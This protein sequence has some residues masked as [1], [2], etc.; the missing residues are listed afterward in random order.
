MK[1]IALLFVT[2]L[3]CHVS[4][5]EWNSP[6]IQEIRQKIASNNIY[7]PDSGR[8]TVRNYDR[9]K[10][11]VESSI[12]GSANIDGSKASAK[13]N[14]KSIV[15]MGKVASTTMKRLAKGGVAGMLG[16][17]AVQAL[18]DGVGW[19]IDNNQIKKLDDSNDETFE[20]IWQFDSSRQ[21]PTAQQT[22]KLVLTGTG[23]GN[24]GTAVFQRVEYENS[25]TAKCVFKQYSRESFMRVYY[26]QN[27]SYKPDTKPKYL[28]VSAQELADKL[29]EKN[30]SNTD[31]IVKG[32]YTP[33]DSSGKPAPDLSDVLNGL[34]DAISDIVNDFKT[35][36]NSNDPVSTGKT[37]STPSI[38]YNNTVINNNNTTV[39]NT[40]GSTTTTT[41]TSDFQLPAWCDWAFD[42]CQWHR[43]DQQ[44][45][46][47]ET[48]FWEDVKA[49][50]DWTKEEPEQDQEDN[51]QPDVD[52][53]GIFS[54]TFDTV[55]S[56]SKQCP[57][58]LQFNLDTEYLK[59]NY[60]ISLNWLC[61]FFS[62]MGYPLVLS[63]H[64]TGIWILYETVIRKEIKW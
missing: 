25:T 40:D 11:M 44:H 32:G 38:T 62:F 53:Q 59:G 48:T 13:A 22:C 16:G 10:R 24:D 2:F 3:S 55:F 36:I 43:E 31:T 18:V 57:S 50:F 12:Q 4:A 15:N 6:Q 63:S 8:I 46:Q 58:D 1:K 23:D 19:I 61:I 14:I 9:T 27:P 56:L 60:T 29:N 20:Y 49:W 45:Q 28:L 52:D 51:E 35:V 47:E 26:V 33:V 54:R 41:G 21:A 42:M 17:A 34:N 37:D 64:C 5:S 30:D 39:N 7:G